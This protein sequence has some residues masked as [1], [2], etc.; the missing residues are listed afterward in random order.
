MPI[1]ME[2]Q[3]TQKI[4]DGK[5]DGKSKKQKIM[6]TEKQK[7]QKIVDGKIDGKPKKAENSRWE[8]GWE[9]C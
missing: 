6:S 9:N 4:V 3:K 7:K 1:S 5:I 2:N 8:K